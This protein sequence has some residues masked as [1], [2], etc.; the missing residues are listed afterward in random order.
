MHR[1]SSHCPTAPALL[2]ALER[3]GL[4]QGTDETPMASAFVQWKSEATAA[5]IVNMNFFNHTCAYKALLFKLPTLEGLADL[6]RA[7][8]GGGHKN[9]PWPL[10]LVDPPH[11]H[12]MWAIKVGVGNRS[13]AIVRMP[14]RWHQSSRLVQHLITKVI[15]HVNPGGVVV[16][17]YLDDILVVGRHKQEVQLVTDEVTA[18]LRGASFVFGAKSILTPVGEVTWMGKIV[19]AQASRI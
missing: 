11:P 19:N 3:K 8:G 4:V 7:V 16:V 12:L 13:F 10:L 17:P 6:L 2:T 9:R 1:P 15:A 5:L 18:A 14:F